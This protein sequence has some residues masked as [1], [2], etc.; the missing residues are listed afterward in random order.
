MEVA[1]SWSDDTNR[2]FQ[3]TYIMPVEPRLQACWTPWGGWRKCFP[4]AEQQCS[5]QSHD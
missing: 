3:E 2:R 1:E 5:D 4:R